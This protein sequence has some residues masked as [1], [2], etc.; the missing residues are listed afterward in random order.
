MARSITDRRTFLA[1]TTVAAAGVALDSIPAQAVLSAIGR[2][3]IAAIGMGGRGTTLA[4]QFEAMPGVTVKAVYDVDRTR[5]ENAAHAVGQVNRRQVSF[6]QDFRKCLNDP[7][8]DAV[9]IA[10]SNHWH[11]PL[12]LMACKAGKHVYVEK[13]CSH[14]PREGELLIAAARKYDRLIQHGTQRR[15]NPGVRKGLA[16]LQEG[17]I[18]RPYY[19]HCY[20]RGDRPSIGVGKTAPVPDHLDYELWQGPAPRRPYKDNLIHYNWHWHWH[21]GN[22]ELGNNGIHRV[23]IARAALGVSYPNHVTSSGGRYHWPGDDQ[24]TPD[25]QIATFR[26]PGD[27]MITWEALSCCRTSPGVPAQDIWIYG[28]AGAA[29]F[30]ASGY[31][32]FDKNGKQNE[33]HKGHGGQQEHLEN[34]IAALHGKADLNANPVV[35]HQSTLLCHLG[36]IA[37]RKQRALECDPASGRILNNDDAMNL[38]QREYEPGWKMEVS[39]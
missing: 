28:D 24:E 17:A 31:T 2:I 36:N 34:F 3:V 4:S 15:S 21:W 13:P 33:S 10:T 7:D 12:A 9:L 20:F 35:A 18:G 23:D 25:T 39:P 26:F 11:A 8:I 30:S 6:G 32:L 22:G 38:W 1:A 29:A 5:A 37:L 27:R 19:A 16:R 14:N